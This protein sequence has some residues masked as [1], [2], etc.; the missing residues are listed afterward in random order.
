MFALLVGAEVPLGLISGVA[1]GVLVGAVVDTTGSEHEAGHRAIPR[2]AVRLWLPGD[3]RRQRRSAV[4]TFGLTLLS[5]V[6]AC[7]AGVLVAMAN[8]P[9]FQFVNGFVGAQ[10]TVARGVLFS[11]WLLIVGGP[12]VIRDPAA[13]G[14]QL[15][16]IRRQW[17]IVGGVIAAAAA[18]TAILL[19]LVGRTPYSDASLFIETV[20]VPFTEELLFRGVLLTVLLHGLRQLHD[21]R[22]AVV[23]AVAIDGL[24]FGLAHLA[25]AGSIELAFVVSQATFASLLGVAC[26]FLMVRTK[27]VYPAMLLHAV[28]NGVVVAL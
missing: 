25:N 1:L 7:A 2:S 11:T 22:T 20:D 14:F 13:Y 17:R 8:T 23:L 28:V 4:A 10:E 9:Y 26:A 16:E 27:S 12:F 5:L 18:L 6:L 3:R 19:T 15:G 21:A 24:A